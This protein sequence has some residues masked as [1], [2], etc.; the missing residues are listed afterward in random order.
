MLLLAF[1]A[2]LL[3]A[4]LLSGLAH[5]TIL[6]TAVVFLA[7][8]FVLGEGTTGLLDL[9][10]VLFTDEMR[11]GWADLRSAWRLPGRALG[12]GLPLP[13]G[14]TTVAASVS[15]G[16]RRCSSA[17]S[18]HPALRHVRCGHRAAAGR[19]IGVLFGWTYRDRRSLGQGDG[20]SGRL[21]LGFD[22]GCWSPGGDRTADAARRGERT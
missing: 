5:R 10:A 20:R 3:L 12:W 4:V 11:V 22:A 18:S 6:S 13:L 1:V 15:T 14:I 16:P 9:F 8:G 17:R 19:S 21:R 7:A 2:V